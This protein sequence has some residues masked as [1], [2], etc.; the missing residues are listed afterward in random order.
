M[1]SYRSVIEQVIVNDNQ[2]EKKNLPKI[3]Q[4]I[5]FIGAIV[6]LVKIYY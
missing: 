6:P 4:V 2:K 1:A 3:F 5:K